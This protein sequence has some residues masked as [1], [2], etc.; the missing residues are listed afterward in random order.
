[1]SGLP[2]LPG[3]KAASPASPVFVQVRRAMSASGA[4]PERPQAPRS[5][6]SPHPSP[7]KFSSD[8]TQAPETF[9][10][11]WSPKFLPKVL[12]PSTRRPSVTKYL[13]FRSR[14]FWKKK[15]EFQ[16]FS[17]VSKPS[18]EDAELTVGSAAP[19]KPSPNASTLDDMS[20][21]AWPPHEKLE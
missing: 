10:Y 12:L 15:P 2:R 13:L 18:V 14:T 4:R 20:P 7:Q 17:R 21:V 3:V 11:I 1:M 16:I 9:G 6:N 19:G 5:L 8:T